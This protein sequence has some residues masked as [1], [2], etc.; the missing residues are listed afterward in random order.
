MEN[1]EL[2]EKCVDILEEAICAKPCDI[3]GSYAHPL[4]YYA[5]QLISIIQKAER[6]KLFKAIDGMD[7]IKRHNKNPLHS[8]GATLIDCPACCWY[9][10]KALKGDNQ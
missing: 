9:A 4:S 7:I 6:E 1:K 2:I 10:Y 3:D 8:T 5:Q